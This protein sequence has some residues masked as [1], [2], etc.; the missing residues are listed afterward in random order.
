MMSQL[1]VSYPYPDEIVV[2]L[3]RCHREICK[4]GII[5]RML[6]YFL[7][8]E[9]NAHMHLHKFSSNKKILDETRSTNQMIEFVHA[10]V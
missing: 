4:E 3:V 6:W 7:F 5:K 10:Q 8:G 1:G 2:V 9:K